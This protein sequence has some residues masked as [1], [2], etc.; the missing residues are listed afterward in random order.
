MF[1]ESAAPSSDVR[2]VSAQTYG[3]NTSPD[4]ASR[5]LCLCFIVHLQ[6]SLK[7][8]QKFRS[9]VVSDSIVQCSRFTAIWASTFVCLPCKTCGASAQDDDSYNTSNFSSGCNCYRFVSSECTPDDLPLVDDS[10]LCEGKMK[11]VACQGVQLLRGE[12]YRR[13][14]GQDTVKHLG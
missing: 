12:R 9:E 7:T 11:E 2:Y 6:D 4:S 1:G 8:F 10:F 3:K 14:S 13:R 5:H